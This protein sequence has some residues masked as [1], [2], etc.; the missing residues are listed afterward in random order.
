MEGA[1]AQRYEGTHVNTNTRGRRRTSTANAMYGCVSPREPKAAYTIR[2]NS[3]T[4]L[5]AERNL[6]IEGVA[7][8]VGGRGYPVPFFARI[9]LST[10]FRDVCPTRRKSERTYVPLPL[11]CVSGFHCR[12]HAAPMPSSSPSINVSTRFCGCGR[13]TSRIQ[14]RVLRPALRLHARRAPAIDR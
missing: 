4:R 10:L 5:D 6:G 14:Q 1:C 7:G 2:M 9:S 11:S 3:F 8:S 12:T 13:P